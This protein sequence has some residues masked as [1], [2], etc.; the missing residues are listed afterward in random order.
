MPSPRSHPP[1][2]P[3]WRT[4]GVLLGLLSTGLEA[5]LARTTVHHGTWHRA[6]RV[7]PVPRLQAGHVSDCSAFAVPGVATIAV[8]LL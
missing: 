1:P 6:R 5:G 2:H 3:P 8:L 4:T 7:L